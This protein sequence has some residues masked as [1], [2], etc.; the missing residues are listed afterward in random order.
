LVR[1]RYVLNEKVGNPETWRYTW[2]IS[3]DVTLQSRCDFCG[4]DGLR[5]TYEVAR[6]DVSMWICANCV[7]RYPVGADLDGMELE[8][9]YARAHAHG[10]TARLKQQTCQDTI[11]RVQSTLPDPALEEVV[12]YFDRNLQLSPQNAARLF[13]A[14]LKIGE[15]TDARIFEIQTRSKAHQDEFGDMPEDDR[16][17]VWIALTPQQRRRLASL[18]HAPAGTVVRRG[19]SFTHQDVGNS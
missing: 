9:P 19:R 14:M 15:E 18:G 13:G 11:R 12:V 6:Q 17:L 8:P 1:N 4:R 3:D 16:R 5:L 10:L 2:A 7:G